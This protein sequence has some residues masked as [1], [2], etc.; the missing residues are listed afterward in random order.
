[1]LYRL[2]ADL[3][4]VVHLAFIA[5]VVLGGFLAWR[6]P[7]VLWVHIPV[8]AW[9]LV[10]VVFSVECPLTPLENYL[11]QLAGQRGYSGSFIDHYLTGVIYP[12]RLLGLTRALAA[13]VVLIAYA[14]LLVRRRRASRSA[15]KAMRRPRTAR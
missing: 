9:A 7:R 1:M 13:V 4:V 14:G 12:G 2:L 10:I 8:I 5:F 6:W 3:V 11:R 15:N